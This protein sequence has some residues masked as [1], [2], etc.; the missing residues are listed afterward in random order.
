MTWLFFFFFF[1]Q[2][3][4]ITGHGGYGGQYAAADLEHAVGFAYTTSFLDPF[5]SY[6]GTGDPRMM[7]LYDSLYK[8]I[9][10]IEKLK[11]PRV[12]Y[13]FYSE[14]KKAMEDKRSKL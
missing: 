14:Y 11:V 10:Q 13:M 7:S 3:Y 8:C 2:E 5:S 12:T 1:F 6:D 9:L 4:H